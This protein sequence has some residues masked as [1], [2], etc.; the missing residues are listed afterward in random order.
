MAVGAEPAAVLA[1]PSPFIGV[2]NPVLDTLKK[3][4]YKVACTIKR[5]KY[6]C[7]LPKWCRLY[8]WC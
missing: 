7:I 2:P 3:N 4:T 5:I 8:I 1:M 6:E